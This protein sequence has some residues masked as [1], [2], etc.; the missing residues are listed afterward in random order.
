MRWENTIS[1][2]LDDCN[3]LLKM[4]YG[5]RNTIQDDDDDD[6]D[7]YYYYCSSRSWSGLTAHHDSSVMS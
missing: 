4:L 2:L 3:L 1:V 7:D 6:D 5:T